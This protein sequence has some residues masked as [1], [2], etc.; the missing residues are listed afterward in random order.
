MKDLAKNIDTIANCGARMDFWH[1][2]WF[3]K[4]N[5]G[6]EHLVSFKKNMA[7]RQAYAIASQGLIYGRFAS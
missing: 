1:G 4:T 3:I 5:C 2:Y 6:T 7:L